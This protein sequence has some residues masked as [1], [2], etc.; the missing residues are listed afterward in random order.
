MT[1]FN[2]RTKRA[3]P[4]ANYV[5]DRFRSTRMQQVDKLE[6][7]IASQFAKLTISGAL[8]DAPCGP[9]RFVDVFQSVE[10]YVGVDL[11]EEAII[12]ARLRHSGPGRE[13]LVGSVLCLPFQDNEFDSVFCMRLLHHVPSEIMMAQIIKEIAR[14]SSTYVLLSFY[15]SSGIRYW[16]KRL[17]GKKVSGFPVK[18]ELVEQICQNQGL[19]KI[20]GVKIPKSK[21]MI[22]ILKKIN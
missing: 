9:G 16:L 12:E 8:L 22:F 1:F 11:N 21:Q 18:P 14:V 20:D 15:R 2:T 5:E 6:R 4:A 19:V 17:R 10:R 13:F 3:K 7:Q